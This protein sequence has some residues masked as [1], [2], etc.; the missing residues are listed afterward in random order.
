MPKGVVKCNCVYPLDGVWTI[1]WEWG[2]M[3]RI[4]INNHSWTL[5]GK[6]YTIVQDE[7]GTRFQWPDLVGGIPVVQT[8]VKQEGQSLFW[9]STF[10]DTV[11]QW[12]R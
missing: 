11:T 5:F 3:A 6:N 7:N 2:E 10:D 1:V 9:T 4:I 12:N 8:L